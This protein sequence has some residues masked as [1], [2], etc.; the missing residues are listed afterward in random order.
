MVSTCVVSRNSKGM[1][2][3]AP[4]CCMFTEKY[5]Q[6]VHWSDSRTI[7]MFGGNRI[8]CPQCSNSDR[9]S[10]AIQFFNCLSLGFTKSLH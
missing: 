5:F 7:K 6:G 3:Y 9:Y 8:K 2:L 1:S 4:P 10:I